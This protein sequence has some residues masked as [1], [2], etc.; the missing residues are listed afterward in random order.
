MF[1]STSKVTVF[2]RC[3]TDRLEHFCS[4][5]I[6][7]TLVKLLMVVLHHPCSSSF[8]FNVGG[9]TTTSWWAIGLFY[10]SSVLPT[11]YDKPIAFFFY[12]VV[13]TSPQSG[14]KFQGVSLSNTGKEKYYITLNCSAIERWTK[15]SQLAFNTRQKS[16]HII[17]N[18]WPI[19]YVCFSTNKMY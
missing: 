14:P 13:L 8:L 15:K 6:L 1:S 2:V 18:S 7:F 17:S 3:R 4:R 5:E 11:V 16:E 19:W 9:S 12:A 10:I